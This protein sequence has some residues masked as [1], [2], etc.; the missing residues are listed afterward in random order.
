MDTF[1]K[2]WAKSVSDEKGIPIFVESG[3][4]DSEKHREDSDINSVKLIYQ[5]DYSDIGYHIVID[6]WIVRCLGDHKCS[7]RADI[8]PI[9][10]RGC[11]DGD[12]MDIMSGVFFLVGD[13]TFRT[14][15]NLNE[16]NNMYVVRSVDDRDI[17]EAPPAR[18]LIFGFLKDM[19]MEW[20]KPT[21]ID[22]VKR[23]LK[24]RRRVRVSKMRDQVITMQHQLESLNK[25]AAGLSHEISETYKSMKAIQSLTDEEIEKALSAYQRS[26]ENDGFNL[27][28]TDNGI[29]YTTNEF[30]ICGQ[31]IGPLNIEMGTDFNVKVWGCE[32]D[33][34]SASGYWHP[35]VNRSGDV[36]W[37]VDGMSMINAIKRTENPFEILF[38]VVDFLKNCYCENDAWCPIHKWDGVDRYMCDHCQEHH[39]LDE[40][41]PNQCGWCEEFV[42]DFRFH[43]F[44]DY[45]GC[46]DFTGRDERLNQNRGDEKYPLCPTCRD[47]KKEIKKRNKDRER[48]SSDPE[49]ILAS[50]DNSEVLEDVPF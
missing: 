25:Q 50:P 22:V 19:I 13:T 27:D 2:D 48:E 47:E 38:V 21:I 17:T 39:S 18:D 33:N 15:L 1:I 44:C 4:A 12:S 40:G 35:H 6:G 23:K 20:E 31:K 29:L 30:E 37:G 49:N 14:V 46:F 32:E 11:Y 42:E 41:C 8:T 26:L 34:M 10:V 3:F 36:C 9:P 45:H 7:P 28:I 5:A 16:I 43:K 24:N